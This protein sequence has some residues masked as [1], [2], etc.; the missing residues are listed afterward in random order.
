VRVYL[1]QFLKRLSDR[2]V[3]DYS[4]LREKFWLVHPELM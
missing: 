3:V 2:A 1:D 4:P